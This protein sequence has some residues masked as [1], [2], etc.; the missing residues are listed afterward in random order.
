M[1]ISTRVVT[2]VNLDIEQKE[3]LRKLAETLGDSSVEPQKGFFNRIF[4]GND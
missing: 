1:L 4:G 3:L 2:P